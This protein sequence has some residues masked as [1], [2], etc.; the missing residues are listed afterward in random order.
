LRAHPEGE[1]PAEEIEVE[2]AGESRNH[3]AHYE[4]GEQQ[5]R[6]QDEIA[7]P[8]A[9]QAVPG[10]FRPH[11]VLRTEARNATAAWPAPARSR[12]PR[13]GGRRGG[14]R[15]AVARVR[16]RVLARARSRG[17]SGS[18]SPGRPGWPH[19]GRS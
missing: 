3:E 10:V 15:V 8:V 14:A 11:G 12:A 16:A 4:P 18:G 19:A 5:A 13:P 2:V 7:T 6:R 17:R 1:R 9:L